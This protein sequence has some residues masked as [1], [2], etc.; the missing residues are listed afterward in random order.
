LVYLNGKNLKL[1]YPTAKLA[2]KHQGPL[3][4]IEKIGMSSYKLKVLK[5]WRI[6]DVFHGTLLTPY[7]ETEA[8][9]PNHLKPLP[10]L[11]DNEEEYEVEQ[12]INV[13]QYG[14]Q[15]KCRT[16]SNGRDI[17]TWRTPGSPC[18]TLGTLKV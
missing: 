16:L 15:Q 18:Q 7:V 2:P 12:I 8:R 13:Q 3:E 1:N 9:R 5:H 14:K 4:I 17:Q 10:T 6:H 11:I